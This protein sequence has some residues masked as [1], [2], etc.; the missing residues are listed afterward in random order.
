MRYP[1]VNY[2]SIFNGSCALCRYLLGP[3]VSKFSTV[4]IKLYRDV[5]PSLLDPSLP[6]STLFKCRQHPGDLMYVP[7]AWAHAVYND[8]LTAGFALE[9]PSELLRYSGSQRT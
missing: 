1:S 7:R 4:P 3:S 6:A 5:L 8:Q 9:F 2:P